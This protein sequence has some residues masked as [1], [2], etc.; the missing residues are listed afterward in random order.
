MLIVSENTLGV[1]FFFL[2]INVTIK[3]YKSPRNRFLYIWEHQRHHVP[4]SLI[5]LLQLKTS[6]EI[7][8]NPNQYVLFLN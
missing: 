2:T 3:K 5:A 6:S 4:S 1:D 8:I 7:V